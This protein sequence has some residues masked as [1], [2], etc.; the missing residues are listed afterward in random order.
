VSRNSCLILFIQLRNKR[1]KL[2][3]NC[4]AISA[5][6]LLN[7]AGFFT[8][9][10][11]IFNRAVSYFLQDSTNRLAGLTGNKFLTKTCS[12]GFQDENFA[13]SSSKNMLIFFMTFFIG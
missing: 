12:N 5:D 11:K 13:P 6:L 2:A 1:H 7:L 10:C 9:T 8:V 4:V 3:V